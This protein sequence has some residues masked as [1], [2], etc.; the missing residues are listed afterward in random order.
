MADFYTPKQNHY[1]KQLATLMFSIPGDLPTGEEVK[2][3]WETE[4]D[5]DAWI[6]DQWDIQR[7]A[8]RYARRREVRVI[9]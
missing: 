3:N 6:A 1:L 9:I 7:E 5:Y 2:G 8:K 4:A